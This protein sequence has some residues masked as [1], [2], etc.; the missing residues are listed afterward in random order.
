MSNRRKWLR[1]VL[2]VLAGGVFA[3]SIFMLLQYQLARNAS[4]AVTRE[5]ARAAV[6]E[7]PPLP[8]SG[9]DGET[10]P[11]TTEEDIIR[12]TAPIQVDFEELTEKNPDVVAWLY[13]PDTPI[14]YPVAQ[15]DDNSYYLHR[16]VNGA[17]N[18]SGTLFLDYRNSG[19][20]SDGNSLIYGHNMR[21]GSMFG[22][23]PKYKKQ[24]YYAQHPVLYLL[25]P[26]ADYKVELLA[27]YVTPADAAIY[28]IPLLNEDGSAAIGE[29]IAPSRFAEAPEPEEDGR[30]LTLSTC[31]YEFTQARYVVVGILRALAKNK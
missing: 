3:F 22:S 31:S 8:S 16:L 12:E 23:L 4:D 27:G 14:N 25:T 28:D 26:D 30:Y 21:N 29:L 11:E 10:T 15:S 9:G 7:N 13:C 19:D 6:S 18:F 5:W 1:G 24:G 20:F 17:Y 2:W